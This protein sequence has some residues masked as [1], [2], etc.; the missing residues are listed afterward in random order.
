LLGIVNCEL[1]A[2]GLIAAK[3][4]LTV[5]L[6]VRV[7]GTNAEQARQLLSTVPDIITANNLD[8]AAQKVVSLSKA[9]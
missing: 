2:K 7:E 3:S 5:P 4:V 1:I 6:V 9:V 8:D